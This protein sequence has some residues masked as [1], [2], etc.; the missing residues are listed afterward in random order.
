MRSTKPI[1][2]A[3][4]VIAAALI[5]VAGGMLSWLADSSVPSA[6]LTGGASFGGAVLL[7]LAVVYFLDD[8]RRN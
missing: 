2:M 4:I 6:F 1:W 5:G 3:I 8:T 7:M